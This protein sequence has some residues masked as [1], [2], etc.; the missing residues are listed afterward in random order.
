MR[1]GEKK[2]G[3]S[4]MEWGSRLFLFQTG[5]GWVAGPLDEPPSPVDLEACSDPPD[6]TSL[7]LEGAAGRVARVDEEDKAGFV[8]F[9]MNTRA[10]Q[11]T[12]P[13]WTGSCKSSRQVVDSTTF[14]E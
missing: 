8:E 10:S 11:W 2:N 3:G 9:T 4:G 6:R 7:S 12:H 13:A 1:E 5:D 14:R